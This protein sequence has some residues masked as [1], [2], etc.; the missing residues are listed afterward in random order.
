MASHPIR[1][2]QLPHRKPR[3]VND[4]KPKWVSTV[5]DIQGNFPEQ[6]VPEGSPPGSIIERYYAEDQ[7]PGSTVAYMIA[8]ITDGK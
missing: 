3:R 8:S 4:Y 2:F 6:V 1:M 7:D 5:P